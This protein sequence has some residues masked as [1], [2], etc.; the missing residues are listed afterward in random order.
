MKLSEIKDFRRED[1]P[2]TAI[3]GGQFHVFKTRSQKR[4]EQRKAGCVGMDNPLHVAQLH[5]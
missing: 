4:K 3:I 2:Y 1:W 5:R